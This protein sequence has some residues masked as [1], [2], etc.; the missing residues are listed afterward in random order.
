MASC[1]GFLTPVGLTQQ[2][3][4]NIKKSPTSPSARNCEFGLKMALAQLN[5]AEYAI[6]LIA[7]LLAML[8][9]GMGLVTLI[10]SVAHH[11]RITTD[12]NKQ[13]VVG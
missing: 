3:L 6:T 13:P 11:H 2:T 12:H 7:I 10:R 5:N 1:G 9:I 4:N 8:A